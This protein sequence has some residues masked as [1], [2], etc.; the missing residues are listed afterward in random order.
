MYT[1]T[2][3]TVPHLCKVLIVSYTAEG[4]KNDKDLNICKSNQM[5]Q[6]LGFFLPFTVLKVELKRTT[7]LCK[8][9][10]ICTTVQSHMYGSSVLQCLSMCYCPQIHVNI[11]CSSTIVVS[12]FVHKYETFVIKI[13]SKF[14]L[15]YVFGNNLVIHFR[16]IITSGGETV[17]ISNPCVTR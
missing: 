17:F 9:W 4:S 7:V 16:S 14:K 5:S 6:S 3:R 15:L 10:R 12:C 1:E 11:D 13:K 2:K 8:P